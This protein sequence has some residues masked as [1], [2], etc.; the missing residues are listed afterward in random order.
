MGLKPEVPPPPTLPQAL[1]RWARARTGSEPLARALEAA[2]QAELDGHACAQLDPAADD[3]ASLRAHPW[4]GD[5]ARTTPLVLDA[6]GRCFLWRNFVHE[7]RIAAGIE[8]RCANADDLAAAS[9]PDTHTRADFETLFAG[10]DA[11]AG[12]DQRAAVLRSLGQRLYVLS[13]GPGTGK[14]TTVLRLLLLRLRAAARAGRP[15]AIA[16][17]APTGKAAQRL[18]QALREGVEQLRARL[19]SAV[20]DW[21]PALAALPDGARTLHRLLGAVPG[22][23]RFR[24]D[25]DHPLAHDLVVVDEASMVDLALMRALFDALSPQATLLL[26]GD[27]DQLVSVSAGSVLADLVAAAARPPLAASHAHLAHVWRSAGRLPEVHAAVRAGDGTRVRSLVADGVLAWQDVG[28]E[29][30]LQAQLQRWLQR[31]EW[32]ALEALA[33]DSRSDPA[34]VFATLRRLQLLA[35]L[36]SGAF[37]VDVLNRWIDERQ[38]QRHER[39]LW[40]P[41]RPVLVRHNDYDRRLY[42]GDVGI[43]MRRDGRLLVCFESTDAD[44]RTQHRMLLPTELPEHDL[45][46][47]LSVH[48]SQGSEYAHVAVLLPPDPGN[49]ILARQLLYTAVSRARTGLELWATPASLDAALANVVQRRGGLRERLAG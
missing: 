33:A 31:P 48:Q 44:G 3:F 21:E 45:G 40:Y 46:Y 36:R 13:G 47:A 24:F 34:Q 38:Q 28:D 29:A 39:A 15:C 18:A 4:V 23:D 2:A 25:S 9:T 49:R 11:Q 6:G 42:N 7:Q 17:A 5:G 26:L 14:T 22:E 20:D 37:G 10:V 35:A 16:L 19:G 41:G 32:A 12:G 1:A 43:A 30:T 27:P 8:A